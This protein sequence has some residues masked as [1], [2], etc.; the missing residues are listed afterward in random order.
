MAEQLENKKSPKFK[1]EILLC[2][3][4]G[5]NQYVIKSQ[6]SRLG[7]DVVI[8]NNGKEGV[9]IVSSRIKSGE[10]PFDL[11]FMD[12]YMPVMGG[13]EAA[14]AI[15][16]LGS[17]T[18][19]AALTADAEPASRELYIAHGMPDFLNKPI[20][21]EELWSCLYKHFTPVGFEDVNEKRKSEEEEKQRKRLLTNFVKRN[22]TTFAD[23]VAAIN[24]E[25]IKLAHRLAHTLRGLAGLMGETALQMAARDVEHSLADGNMGNITGELSAL[26]QE[27]KPVLDKLSPLLNEEKPPEPEEADFD[28]AKAFELVGR[29]EPLL[30]IDSAASL[31]LTDELRAFPGT[32]ALIEQIEDYE[33]ETALEILTNLKKSWEG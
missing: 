1:G 31:K 20:V 28:K 4:S 23:I 8:A 22:Q 19:I 16:E 7:F 17:K 18:P 33:F 32:G 12:I 26:E 11:I 24:S 29:L 5:I 25:D 30:Q 13:L 10:R 27:L 15:A 2:E 21:E 6:L 3:D 14:D 9:D